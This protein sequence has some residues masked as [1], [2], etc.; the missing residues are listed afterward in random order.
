MEGTT[1]N[2][3]TI[4]PDSPQCLI[5]PPCVSGEEAFQINQTAIRTRQNLANGVDVLSELMSSYQHDQNPADIDVTEKI[6]V[7]IQDIKE[8]IMGINT[9][10]SCTEN[11]VKEYKLMLYSQYNDAMGAHLHK[12]K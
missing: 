8:L 12:R 4:R 2:N 1:L 6:F 3:R 5:N 11:A 7:M 10:V 9:V